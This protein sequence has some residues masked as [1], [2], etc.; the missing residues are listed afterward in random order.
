MTDTIQSLPGKWR[1]DANHITGA[2]W[3]SP[4]GHGNAARKAVLIACADELEAALAPPAVGEGVR[5]AGECADMAAA[6][7]LVEKAH[8][9][10]DEGV[11]WA[12]AAAFHRATSEIESL[13]S[14]LYPLANT[15]APSREV[16]DAYVKCNCSCPNGLKH[17][18]D[19][20]SKNCL[21][22]APRQVGG[23]AAGTVAD[24]S[25]ASLVE[26]AVRNCYINR[27]RSPRWAHVSDAFALGSTYSA[28]LCRRF[29]LDPDELKGYDPNEAR[30]TEQPTSV[31]VGVDA[32]CCESGDPLCGPVEFHDVEGVPLCRVCWDGLIEDSAQHDGT[33]HG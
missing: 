21:S 4:N 31:A 14:K 18:P 26:R 13:E 2:S 19:A 9:Q 1:A 15:A 8:W 17:N 10:D 33:D 23:E 32:E 5:G 29:C 16:G 20:H 12:P 25:D 22:A 28:Q 27:S 3:N 30:D 6:V 11:W 7:M 24:Y